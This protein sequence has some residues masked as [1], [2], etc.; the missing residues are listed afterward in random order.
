MIIPALTIVGTL[1]AC[2][3]GAD[4]I[5][6]VNGTVLGAPINAKGSSA[7]ANADS[8]GGF[9]VLVMADVPLTCSN[10]VNGVAP[11][12]ARFLFFAFGSA[13]HGVL[14]PASATGTY[15]VTPHVFNG[16]VPPDGNVV[17][18]A[19]VGTDAQCHEV[20]SSVSLGTSGTVELTSASAQ[21]GGLL[22]GSFQVVLETGDAL[23]GSFSA[24]LCGSPDA[25]TGVCQ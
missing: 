8:R 9:Q 6:K 18:I 22:E 12:S 2:G 14:S 24:H 20:R 5:N 19:Y 16:D 4:G 15:Q 13:A 10:I 1:C 23:N 21:V 17:G 3:R 7:S 25:G 11:K